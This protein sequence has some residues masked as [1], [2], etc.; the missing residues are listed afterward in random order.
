MSLSL[1]YHCTSNESSD[2]SVRSIS[3]KEKITF[4]VFLSLLVPCPQVGD[5]AVLLLYLLLDKDAYMS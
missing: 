3:S 2:L 4:T 1:Q 5:R